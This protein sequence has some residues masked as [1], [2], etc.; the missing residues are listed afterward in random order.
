[1]N[2]HYN[3]RSVDSKTDIPENIDVLLVSGGVDSVDEN[4][5]NNL[6]SFLSAGKKILM[7]QSGVNTDI[8]LQQAFP[9]ESNIFDFLNE[10]DLDLQKNLVLDSKCGN[11]Q[12][13][14]SVGL[15]RMNRA[16]QYPFFPVVDTFNSK[17]SVTGII[18]DKLEQ[19]L[20]LFPSEIKIDTVRSEKVLNVSTLFTSSNNSG[21]M[22]SN[23]MLSPDPQQN[24]FLQ[25]LGQ[26]GKVLSALSSLKSGGELM[27]ISDSKFLSDEGG[28]SIPDNMVFLMNAVDYLADDEDLI[29]LRSRE[30]TSRPLDILQLSNEEELSI[31]QD[32]KDKKADR[33]KK[34]WKLANLVLPSILIIGF[35][36]LRIRKEKNQAEV[37]KQIY[38]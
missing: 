1:L 18:V 21:L 17:D 26:S 22:S 33:I 25:L 9:I 38:D 6:T 15:F 12:V 37:L 11:V 5:V 3:F 20:P 14:Q 34:R 8:Q 19:I 4:T 7:T 10:Y 32:D 23:F 16:V 35:G 36:I 31:S 27:L 24:P 30:V 28:M 2:Q 29:S 13:Q